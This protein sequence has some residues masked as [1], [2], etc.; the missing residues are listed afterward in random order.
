MYIR[1]VPGWNANVNGLRKPSAQTYFFTDRIKEITYNPYWNV[2][3][4]IVINEMLAQ[5][6]ID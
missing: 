1:P 3:R 6:M 2:P 5:Q 4:S